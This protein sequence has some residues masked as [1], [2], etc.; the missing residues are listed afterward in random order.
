M[1]NGSKKPTHNLYVQTQT[2]DNDGNDVDS[3][4]VFIT[5]GFAHGKG[6]GITFYIGGIRFVVFPRRE[7]GNDNP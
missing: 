2:R 1:S 6:E 3:P 5:S 4:L 7:Q